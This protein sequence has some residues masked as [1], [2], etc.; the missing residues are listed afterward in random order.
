MIPSEVQNKSPVTNLKEIETWE[1]PHKNS[2]QQS[3]GTSVS[4]KRTQTTKQKNTVSYKR[5]QTTKNTGNEA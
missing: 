2:K 5:T 3:E 1:L 4:Y